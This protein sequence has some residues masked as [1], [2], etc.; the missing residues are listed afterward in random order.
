[1]SFQSHTGSTC[2]V[3][4]RSARRA[5]SLDVRSLSPNLGRL[6]GNRMTPVYPLYRHVLG[7]HLLDRA[8]FPCLRN[9]QWACVT[10]QEGRGNTGQH[11][12]REDSD[13]Q[14]IV[15]YPLLAH[16]LRRA[17]DDALYLIVY[18]PTYS[19]SVGVGGTG[20]VAQVGLEEP[21]GL[22]PCQLSIRPSCSSDR[23]SSAPLTDSSQRSIMN[24]SNA[25]DSLSIETRR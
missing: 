5:G 21:E 12:A 2:R 13:W 14:D 20:Q 19:K 4:P 11:Y 25:M 10:W 15:L 7:Y 16:R 6:S 1:M 17:E 18:P 23:T 8:G 3:S 22:N 24:S 9:R